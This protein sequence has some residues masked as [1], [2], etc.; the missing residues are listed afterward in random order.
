MRTCNLFRLGVLLLCVAP[1]SAA[2][3]L[4]KT[5]NSSITMPSTP[6]M[7]A[8]VMPGM[9]SGFYVPG[10]K[11]FYSGTNP[12]VPKKSETAKTENDSSKNN[13]S[14]NESSMS[15]AA[16]NLQNPLEGANPVVSA[17]SSITNT[18]ANLNQLTASDLSSMDSM[19]L[20]GSLGGLL[21]GKNA[22]LLNTNSNS[23]LVN[24]NSRDSKTL[25]SILSQ[26]TELKSQVSENGQLQ[27]IPQSFTNVKKIEPKILRFSVNGN[28]LISSCRK[29]Y[30]SDQE[31]DGTFLLT[32]DRKYASEN[33]NHNETF[34]F[35]FHAKGGEG[36]VTR[37]SVTPAISQDVEDTNSHLYQLTQENELEAQR[38][39]NLVTLRATDG[40]WKMDLLV[41][42]DK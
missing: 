16:N 3:T 30:F 32:G 42:L 1:V 15:V 13:G 41:S 27:Q 4:K 5:D 17:L 39:G 34:Y 26:L 24:Q 37:Y 20:F 35:Y 23:I 18:G 14:K 40:K 19:G 21:G 33:K 9:G 11:G 36:G 12:Y 31:S 8:V 29:I 38:T 25:E 10:A 28:D 6:S 7:P 2:A 22:G